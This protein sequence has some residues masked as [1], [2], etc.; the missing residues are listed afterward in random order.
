MLDIDK[1]ILNKKYNEGDMEY[2]FD[3]ASK[4]ADFVLTKNYKVYDSEKRADMVQE[5][6]ENLW[7]KV[8]QGKV[9]GSKNL[10]SFIWQN[11]TFRIKEILRKENNRNRIAP[12][13][14][15]DN[16]EFEFLKGVDSAKYGEAEIAKIF[17]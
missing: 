14:S 5:C 8:Q 3:K 17:M 11:S 6:L 12:F 15:Y 1:E 13:I 4:I 7:K 10:M 2:F 9:D 16:E